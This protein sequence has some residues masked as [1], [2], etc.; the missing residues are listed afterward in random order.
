MKNTRQPAK[1]AKATLD[2]GA[3]WPVYYALAELTAA[4]ETRI[5]ALIRQAVS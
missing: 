3:M 4:G 1:S 5:A 2:D